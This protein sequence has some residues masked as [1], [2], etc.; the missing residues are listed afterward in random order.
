MCP[1]NSSFFSSF[2]FMI[3]FMKSCFPVIT[4]K[5]GYDKIMRPVIRHKIKTCCIALWVPK[6][7]SVGRNFFFS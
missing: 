3:S 1:E 2:N 6:H 4:G 5:H 7:G